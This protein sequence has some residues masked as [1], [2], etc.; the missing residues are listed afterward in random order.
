MAIKKSRRM[1]SILLMVVMIFSMQVAFPDT[2]NA[3]AYVTPM[4]AAGSYHSLALKNDGTVW[5]WGA[6]NY[7]QVGDGSFTNRNSPVHVSGISGVCA[8]AGG[9]YHSLALKSDGT[10]WA[11]GRN[12]NGQLGDGTYGGG[13]DKGSPVRVL[14]LSGVIAIAG[15]QNHSLALKSDG[16]VR[17]WGS[18]YYGQLG[19]G[20]SGAYSTSPVS[21]SGLTDVIAI[22][23]GDNHSFALKSNG[24]V[25]A[26]GRN[27]DGQL[28]NG[29]S[30]IGT[31]KSS[32]VKVSGLTG[33]IALA[34]GGFHCF[35]LKN[36]GT[37]MAWGYN[38][39]GQL[40]NGT[41]GA[42]TD[43]SSPIQVPGLTG[44]TAMAGGYGH[45]LALISDGTVRA[46]GDNNYGQLGIG[47]STDKRSPEQII[48]L[49]SVIA[50]AAG[51]Y[52]TLALKSDGT[53]LVW[54]YNLDG[55]LGFGNN[56]SGTNK[57]SPV[58]AKG[59]GASGSLDLG[60]TYNVTLNPN[61]GN[62]G[63]SSV[64]VAAGAAMPKIVPP[65]RTGYTFK[66]Y[67]DTSASSG[68]K[69]YYK[70]SGDSANVW[71][72]NSDKTLWARWT[73]V[74]SA[75][76]AVKVKAVKTLPAVYIVKGKSVKLPAA[77]QPYNATNKNV[78]FKSKDKKIVKVTSAGKIK[79]QKTGK[80]TITITTKDGNKKA[81]CKVYVVK[82]AVKLKKLTLNQKAKVNLKKGKTLEV[83]AKL[84][85]AK[86]TGIVPKFTSGN[87]SVAVI[88]KV[89]TITA[90]KAGKTTITVKAG[91][92]KKT[93][94][95]T[96]K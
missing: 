67:W 30:G 83:K 36:D 17:A 69:Q 40:G 54:G 64:R 46:W 93:I 60:A 1:L 47:S 41:G 73:A 20:T 28:G 95:L 18:N 50:I 94:K 56:G 4:L 29:T 87:T 26:W 9:S 65:T 90:L 19:N 14:G 3:A 52:H 59:P 23:V 96:V 31:D 51:D 55:Q 86:A 66:G 44:V 82:K 10:V 75:A 78:A 72:K 27:I 49:S 74:K 84:S 21:V 33:V 5:T 71:D 6:N 79:G 48:G 12:F 42:G 92:Y 16:T 58:Q 85:P 13:A 7:G 81:T 24:T 89:G 91:K 32:P 8:I 34:G 62:Q 11:W 15:G 2:V 37:A 25:W 45:S 43:K 88:D 57:N 80:T 39:S 76:P 22:A 77:V 63:T 70:E 68:G 35:A 61:G 53:V 38:Y